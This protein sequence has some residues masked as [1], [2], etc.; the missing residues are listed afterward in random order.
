MPLEQ[1]ASHRGSREG[2]WQGV[3]R[4][5]AT[6]GSRSITTSAASWENFIK[7]MKDINDPQLK[8]TPSKIIHK[9]MS[10]F[11]KQYLMRSYKDGPDRVKDIEEFESFARKYSSLKELIDETILKEDF[12]KDKFSGNKNGT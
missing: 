4:W 9:I 8:K 10:E 7:M 2:R 3:A 11:Y 12:K 6:S 1:R 5:R